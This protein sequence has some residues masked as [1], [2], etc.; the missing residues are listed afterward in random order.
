MTKKEATQRWNDP[1]FVAGLRPLLEQVFAEGVPVRS[2]KLE[3]IHIG[4]KSPVGLF[5]VGLYQKEIVGSDF[6]FSIFECAFAGS[7][8]LET[9]FHNCSFESASF[10]KSSVIK[11]VFSEALFKGG[12]CNDS[13][14]E[15]CDFSRARLKDKPKLP[16]AFLRS[17]FSRCDF[18]G[19]TIN[20]V[21]F[22]AAKFESCVFNGAKF[23]NCDF[24]G[25]KFLDGKPTED[26]FGNGCSI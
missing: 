25:V 11:C 3:G 22:R 1:N 23:T 8:I 15:E 26:Q 7:T 12:G 4:S 10:Q 2:V 24:R 6:S 14:F 9:S 5:H 13:V 21:E 16:L 20:G 17:R 18:T 19:A